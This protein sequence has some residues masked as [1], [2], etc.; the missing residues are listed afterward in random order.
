L[1]WAWLDCAN[2][3]SHR[4]TKGRLVIGDWVIGDWLLGI[5]YW[6]LVIG[7]WLL[8]IGYWVIGDWVIGYCHPVT[9]SP[10]HPITL[11]PHHLVPHH[12][13]IPLPHT[14]AVVTIPLCFGLF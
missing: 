5:G 12:L 13:V 4:Q 3:F 11:S 10:C 7:D 8:G 6:G 2:I 14:P 1:N 9:P